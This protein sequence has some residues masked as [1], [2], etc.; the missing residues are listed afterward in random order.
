M[1][2]MWEHTACSQPRRKTFCIVLTGG[3][4]N[5]GWYSN[6]TINRMG[7]IRLEAGTHRIEVH[8]PDGSKTNVMRFRALHLDPQ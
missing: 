8:V 5:E 7:E 4:E 2:M 1:R 6:Y 3:E